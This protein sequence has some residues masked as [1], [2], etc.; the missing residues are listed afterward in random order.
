MNKNV[1][2]KEKPLNYVGNF[3]T[4]GIFLLKNIIYKEM[5]YNGLVLFFFNGL[6]LLVYYI[7]KHVSIS[8]ALDN[9]KHYITAV[10]K[11]LNYPQIDCTHGFGGSRIKGVI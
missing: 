3:P 1:F 10:I 7:H 9:F 11:E 6:V 4:C 5:K 8:T 2:L